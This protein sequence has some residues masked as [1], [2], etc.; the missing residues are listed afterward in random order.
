[1]AAA[2]AAP[3]RRSP[4]TVPVVVGHPGGAIW[5]CQW[6]RQKRDARGDIRMAAVEVDDDLLTRAGAVL[7]TTTHRATVN[8][9]LRLVLH[10]HHAAELI[11]LLRS[12]AIEIRDHHQLR[13]LNWS[14]PPQT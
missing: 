11:A 10:R 6:N 14:P 1:M 9:A 7:G 8:T 2:R 5:A 13:R 12:D 3:P 4:G